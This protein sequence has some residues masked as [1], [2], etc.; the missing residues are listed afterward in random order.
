MLVVL[1]IVGMV[2]AISIDSLSRVF[3]LRARLSAYL[4]AATASRMTTNWLRRSTTNLVPDLA[5]SPNRF[6]GTASQ[7]S[8]VTLAPLGEGSGTPTAIAW[9]LNPDAATRGVRLEYQT[10]AANWVTVAAWPE[11]TGAFTYDGGDGQWVNE[12]PPPFQ[13]PNALQIPRYI[14]AV[15]GR[16]TDTWSIVM[17]PVGSLE[18]RPPA[19]NIRDILGSQTQNQ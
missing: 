12:W 3:D 8:G 1:V 2:A 10:G 18:A 5:T 13:A 15:V 6:R 17:S 7:F 11:R 19:A 16:G 9:R 4:D 14:R